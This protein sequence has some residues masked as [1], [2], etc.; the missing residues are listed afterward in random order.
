MHIEIGYG[1]GGLA[2]PPAFVLCG[3]YAYCPYYSIYRTIL[4]RRTDRA[5]I[6]ESAYQSWSKTSNGQTYGAS[7]VDLQTIFFYLR[8]TVKFC[9]CFLHT[10]SRAAARGQDYEFLLI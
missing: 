8:R 4:P 9:C 6:E 7:G 10:V 3:C 1:W 2:T 5:P